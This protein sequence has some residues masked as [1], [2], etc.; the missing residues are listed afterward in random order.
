[1]V[2]GTSK[3]EFGIQIFVLD[4]YSLL[5]PPLPG[6][7]ASL[8]YPPLPLASLLYP[9]LPGSLASLLYPP[10]PGSLGTSRWTST[11]SSSDSGPELAHNSIPLTL[12]GGF[13]DWGGGSSDDGQH[14]CD[15]YKNNS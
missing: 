7:L 8:L 12:D 6:S 4:N 1:M 3:V 15:G 9:P 10:L 5:Y 2:M 13:S 14:Y 11:A